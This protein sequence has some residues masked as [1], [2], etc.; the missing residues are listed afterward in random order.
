M[1][2]IHIYNYKSTIWEGSKAPQP[3]IISPT[4]L[5][6]SKVINRYTTIYNE[7]KSAQSE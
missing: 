3:F 5:N 7:I 1:D 4:E 6:E 2:L